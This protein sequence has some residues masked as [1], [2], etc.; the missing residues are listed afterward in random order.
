MKT[1]FVTIQGTLFN[2]PEIVAMCVELP[3]SSRQAELVVETRLK[4]HFFDYDDA[5]AAR[6]VIE[7]VVAKL[8]ADGYEVPAF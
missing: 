5:K 7:Q 6:K 3:E 2:L 1:L 8:K 4:K